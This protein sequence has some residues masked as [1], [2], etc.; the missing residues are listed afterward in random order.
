MANQTIAKPLSLIKDRKFFVHGIPYVVI[1][2]MIQSSVLDSNYSMLLGHP[3]LKDVKVSHDWGNNT[4]IIQRT[5]IV[6]TI[7]ITKKLGA[8]TKCPKLLVC[9][10]F[11]FKIFDE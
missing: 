9:Y 10:D 7:P 5:D 2:T 8:P 6:K 1:F 3:W 4:I 11:H